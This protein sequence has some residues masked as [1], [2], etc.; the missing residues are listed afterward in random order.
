MSANSA[1]D[2]NARMRYWAQELAS[3][4]QTNNLHQEIKINRSRSHKE[5]VSNCYT[6]RHIMI[7]RGNLFAF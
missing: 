5:T 1:H 2:R 7:P 4:G 3:S 6:L